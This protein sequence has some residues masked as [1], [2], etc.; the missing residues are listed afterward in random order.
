MKKYN[1]LDELNNI[2]DKTIEKIINID[3]KE[4]L[5]IEKRKYKEEN[6]MKKF[7]F[8]PICATAV[9]AVALCAVIVTN[10]TKTN[11]NIE[12]SERVQIASPIIEVD[13]REEMKKYLGFDVPNV[14]LKNIDKYI[15][16]GYDGY[17]DLARVLFEDE[18]EFRMSRK[19]DFENISGIF[20]GKIDRT[21]NIDG[22]NVEIYIYNDLQYA[23]WEVGEY[24][25]CYTTSVDD[26]N[27]IDF[28][29]DVI[30]ISK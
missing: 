20:G 8:V 12:M 2:E 22:V 19:G 13:T 15:V 23:L 24:E 17:A 9:C 21:E 16:V 1:L 27:L 28:V 14:E 30:N 29:T 5:E 7:N 10:Q 6:K 25:Y 18:T 11:K 3:S 26:A 4:K